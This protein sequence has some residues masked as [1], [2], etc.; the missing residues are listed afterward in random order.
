MATET[1]TWLRM[2]DGLPVLET[3]RLLMRV[4]NP[5]EE[6]QIVQYLVRNRKH[7][8]PWE[9]KRDRFYF[10]EEAWIGAPE[11]DRAVRVGG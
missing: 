8:E 4:A 3:P 7:L 10:T 5:G 9:Q 2:E 6:H 1:Q 11:R